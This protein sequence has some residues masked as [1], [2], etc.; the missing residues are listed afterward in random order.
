MS[1]PGKN[2][3][4]CDKSTNPGFAEGKEICVMH[5]QGAFTG[6]DQSETLATCTCNLMNFKNQ[7]SLDIHHGKRYRCMLNGV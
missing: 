3:R 6:T 1:R 7:P 4:V 5:N 2:I